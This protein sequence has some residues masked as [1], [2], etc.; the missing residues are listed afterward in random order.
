MI[1]VVLISA[2]VKGGGDHTHLAFISTTLYPACLATTWA[3]VV[4]PSPGG[5]H[6]SATYGK[7]ETM[8]V[9]KRNR[10]TSLF[11]SL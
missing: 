1:R 8:V 3:R 2:Q 5:P 11:L 7:D 6:S 10:F 4:L 9:E